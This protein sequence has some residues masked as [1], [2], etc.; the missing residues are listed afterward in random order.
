MLYE[1]FTTWKQ[2]IVLSKNYTSVW[3]CERNQLTLYTK[4]DWDKKNALKDALE[5]KGN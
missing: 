5:N 2:H 3:D 1:K 4:E